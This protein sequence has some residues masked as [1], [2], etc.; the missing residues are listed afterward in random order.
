MSFDRLV[1]DGIENYIRQNLEDIVEAYSEEIIE[2]LT[3]MGYRIT[4]GNE[5]RR[6]P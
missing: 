6:I 5:P 3:D 1:W 2:I 4:K